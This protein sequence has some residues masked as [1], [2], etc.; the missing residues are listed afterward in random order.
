MIFRVMTAAAQERIVHRRPVD[1]RFVRGFRNE[2][3][4]MRKQV[5]LHARSRGGF[6]YSV[7]EED[8]V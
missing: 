4:F 8:G 5:G 7:G 3:G 6:A 2:A 1:G